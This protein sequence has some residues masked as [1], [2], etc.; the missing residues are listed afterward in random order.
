MNGEKSGT[1][2]TVLVALFY[3]SVANLRQSS[4]WYF[5]KS[6]LFTGV[7]PFLIKRWISIE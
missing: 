6:L 3:E 4:S 7:R 2:G 5:S 1:I